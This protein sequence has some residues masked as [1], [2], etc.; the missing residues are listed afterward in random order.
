MHVLL[1]PWFML[2]SYEGRKSGRRFTIPV[3]YKSVNGAVIVVT[4]TA[5]TNWWKNFK[6][7]RQ[8]RLWVEGKKRPATGQVVTGDEQRQFYR[9]YFQKFRTLGWIL[10][11]GRNA[12]DS[13]QQ[14]NEMKAALTLVR[15]DLKQE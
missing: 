8:C 5:E 9:L 7:G 10:G 4:P 6:S 14:L 15:F 2:I 11:F 3:V 13:T 1:S 12:A